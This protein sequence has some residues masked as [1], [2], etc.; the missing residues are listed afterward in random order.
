MKFTYFLIKVKKKF[1]FF[2]IIFDSSPLNN[3]FMFEIC[4][5]KIITTK[6]IIGKK[7]DHRLFRINSV[8]EAIRADNDEYLV[9]KASN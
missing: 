1:F 4:L 2:K 9:T 3:L 8:E 6:P 5:K 7:N